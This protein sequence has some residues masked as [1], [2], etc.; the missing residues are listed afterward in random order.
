MAKTRGIAHSVRLEIDLSYVNFSDDKKT[1]RRYW[2]YRR[3]SQRLRIHG[4][5]GTPEF[6]KNYDEIHAKFEVQKRGQAGVLPGSIRAVIISYKS[7]PEFKSEIEPRTRQDYLRYMN[8]LEEKFGDLPV[9]AIKKSHVKKIRNKFSDR[10][11]TANYLVQVL[12]ILIEHAIEDMEL[13]ET[14]PAHKVKRLK[15]GDGHR[16]WEESEIAMFRARWPL[17]SFER[18][19]FELGLNTGQRGQD[20]VKMERNHIENGVI[21]VAQLKVGGERVFVPISLD[22]HEALEAWFDAQDDWI[23]ARESGLKPR[24]VPIDVKLMILTGERGRRVTPSYFQHWMIAASRDVKGLAQ[25]LADGGTTTHG[26]RY[27]AATRL[28]ELG[29]SF[30]VIASITG[31][32]TVTMVKKY[33]TKKRNA[34]LAITALNAATEAQKT[35]RSDKSSLE[36]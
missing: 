16:P 8:I 5:Y 22:L 19:A 32:D 4:N 24:P 14:N 12:S 9:A 26:L 18:T 10:P 29:V 2:Y 30:D 20:L 7:S 15:G 34:R 13:R 11:R 31:H 17:G 23:K 3:E 1:G 27:A 21:S 33:A 6:R 35:N 36:K 28:Y 25:G